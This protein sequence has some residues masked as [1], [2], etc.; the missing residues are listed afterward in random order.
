MHQPINQLS[1]VTEYSKSEDWFT[2]QVKP[3]WWE[4]EE[5]PSLRKDRATQFQ[6]QEMWG[7]YYSSLGAHAGDHLNTANRKGMSLDVY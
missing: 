5:K 4:E 1:R 7:Y 6:S 2:W 3:V